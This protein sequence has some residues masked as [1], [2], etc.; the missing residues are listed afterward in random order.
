MITTILWIGGGILMVLGFILDNIK[1]RI[2]GYILFFGL[3]LI[4]YLIIKFSFCMWG[5]C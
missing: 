1:I 5:N 2:T 4:V 3:P